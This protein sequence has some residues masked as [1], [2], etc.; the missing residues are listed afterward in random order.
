MC[1]LGVWGHVTGEGLVDEGKK[2]LFVTVEPDFGIREELLNIGIGIADLVRTRGGNLVH[3][4][5]GSVALLLVVD[6]EHDARAVVIAVQGVSGGIAIGIDV[7][8]LPC[9]P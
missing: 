8:P 2:F 1:G 9:E 5:I 4:G 7:F 6:I 3:L